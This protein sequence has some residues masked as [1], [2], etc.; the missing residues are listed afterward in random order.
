MAQTDI[1]TFLQDLLVRFD[2][3]IDLSDGSRAQTEIIEPILGRIGTDPFDTDIETFVRERITQAFPKLNITQTAALEDTLISPMRVLL[4][5]IVRE[6]KLV[7]LRQSAIAN[8]E[9]VGDD[10]VDAVIANFF[11]GRKTGG[12]A[13]GVVRV[14]FQAPT[15]VSFTLIQVAS[16]R[17]GLR[18]LPS[19]AQTIT[20]DQMLLNRD[21]QEFYCDISYVAEKR[22]DEYN[23][24]RGEIITIANLSSASRVRN[25]NRFDSGVPRENSI[26]LVARVESKQGDRTLTT[27][28][29]I[30]S[31]LTDNFPAVRRI[32]VIGFKDPEMLRDIVKGGG[33]GPAL[34]PD[35]FGP[36]YGAA[37]AVDDGDGN[38][39]T[40]RLSA[41]TGHFVSRIGSAGSDPSAFFLTLVYED[42]GPVLVDARVLEVISDTDVLV[43]YEFPSFPLNVS[44]MLRKRELTISDIPGGITL[45][46]T[47]DGQLIIRS[48]EV[49][50]G[51]K[52]DLYIAGAVVAQTVAIEGISDEQP[53]AR[54]S[55]AQTG[56]ALGS[57]P[58]LDWI[59]INDP[60]GGAA[61]LQALISDGSFSIVL[62][63][64]VDV[65]SY[66]VRDSVVSG[67][68]L[69]VRVPVALTGVVA[70][71]LWK[72]V[73]E[74][75]IEL[76]ETKDIKVEGA[77]LVMVAGNALITTL[78][79]TNF[80]DANVQQNDIV[81]VDADEAGG[82]FT[83]QV[84]GAVSL[85]VSPVPIRTLSNLSYTI[86][87]PSGNVLTPVVRITALDLLDSG[88][89]PNGVKIPYRDPVAIITRGFQNEG[90]GVEFEG[91]PRSIGLVT[92]AIVTSVN[93]GGG[94]TLLFNFRKPL[95]V[96]AGLSVKPLTPG[97][98]YTLNLVGILTP[99]AIAT[100][101]NTT[102]E[103]VERQ[104]RASV[105]TYNG[106]TYVG[107]YC[108]EFVVMGIGGTANALLGLPTS[109]R[110]AT[111]ADIGLPT[112]NPR[113]GDLIEFVDGNN[114]GT[115]RVLRG[116][117][118]SYLAAL[119]GLGPTDEAYSLP[120][121][122]VQVLLP[123]VGVRIRI[124]RP[125]VGS[126][127]VYFLA[128]TSA[129]FRYLTAQFS[130]LVGTDTLLYRPD[131]END[132]VI[133]PPPPLTALPDNGTT[134][135]GAVTTA[136]EDTTV[137][138]Q[139]LGV[140][141]GD[142]LDVLYRPIKSTSP[143]PSPG[144]IS[145]IVGKNL[146]LRLDENP[147]ITVAFPIAL[148]RS[149]LVD[150]INTQVGTDIA[151]IDGSGYLVFQSS[152]LITFRE[153]STIFSPDTL[154]L[155][156][157]PRSSAHPRAGTYIINAVEPTVLTL[158]VDTP[159]GSSS[160]VADTSYR[161]RRALQRIS[162]TEMNN[163][164]DETGLYYVDVELLSL[165]PGDRNNAP[166]MLVMDA[167][168]VV[169]DGYR[170]YANNNTLSYSRAERLFAGISRTILLVGSS[171]SPSE[172][173]Q[174]SRQNVQVSYDQSQLVDDVQSFCDSDFHRVVNEEI[175]VRHLLPHYVNVSW[176]YAGGDTET[177][178][179]AALNTALET[180]EAN[181]Q[182]EVIDVTRVMTARG[183]TS[184]YSLDPESPTG[185]NAPV[186]IVIY[187]DVDRNVRVAI[188]RDYV[189]TSRTQ[190]F[191]GDNLAIV[192]IAP[193]GLR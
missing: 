110:G 29:G 152:S 56:V 16:T 83:V 122:Q 126:A 8:A 42:S 172:Y 55:N 61:A 121:H 38:V 47:P 1:K 64:G 45:P 109:G 95:K 191:I 4:E 24:D 151:T 170:L 70:N 36:V 124:G 123:E 92:G 31:E 51:G 63:E 102:A 77:D 90:S 133:Q 147:W 120:L 98:T 138:F 73:D 93:F 142:Y 52:T 183:A 78:S 137:N 17:S 193:G 192:R 101:I 68:T 48:D 166:S 97:G 59:I 118:T 9:R 10:E 49:H 81:R 141:E 74:I 181:E 140:Q 14:N 21:G 89:A 145:A 75:N 127:R 71:L 129:E 87:R 185:R 182:L 44:W 159:F 2:P 6:V 139:A 169:S 162:S 82:D 84:V 116:H 79:S 106:S 173:V 164:Q 12:Y 91:F 25:L 104:V 149:D 119:V 113:Q 32:Q 175:L 165:A 174:L 99:S 117:E 69:Q 167:V 72:I 125:S 19:P 46:D 33:L 85:Q 111:N 188:V 148:T 146:I 131:P 184:I 153:D 105:L 187:H 96:F 7:K 130:V 160:A 54:G 176:R 190:R 28:R 66:D 135:L 76:T 168:G 177:T 186:M 132:R 39:T 62:D 60:P 128:P 161:I 13:R 15:T 50:I 27:S 103:L 86:F 136:F 155:N 180:V 30:I 34:P 23:V 41:S 107:I 80:I 53:I 134:S 43:D 3:S 58:A 5:P 65:G 37:Q 20:A 11:E 35:T 94:A 18:F 189:Q 26:D 150:Y 100:I 114:R 108:P 22:G 158:S 163:N 171:D 115:T 112:F 144:T 156:G 143:L 179:R 88:G 57:P 157:A 154:F 67:S 40:K 178:M